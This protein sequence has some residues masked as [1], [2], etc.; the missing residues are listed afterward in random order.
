MNTN[1]IENF[2]PHSHVLGAGVRSGQTQIDA[3]PTTSDAV[4]HSPSFR[5]VSR[6]A[7][8]PRHSSRGN[9]LWRG[10]LL[11]LGLALCFSASS[12]EPAKPNIIVIIG[13]DLGYADIGAN[14][15]KE[16]PTPNIDSIAKKGVRF[17]CGYVSG[18]YC[19]PTRAG[20]LS[21]RYQQRFGHEFNPGGNGES[22]LHIGLSLKE[23][24]L[25]EK[26]KEAG[27]KTALVGKWHLG[28]ADQFHPQRRGFDEYFGFTGGAHSYTN[29]PTGTRNSVQRGTNHVEEK[30]F[31]TAAF[32]REALAF[33]ERNKTQP[34][35]LQ[36]AYNAVHGP[37]DTDP[38]YIERFSH[39]TDERRRRFAGLLAGLDDGIGAVLKKLR[40][41]GL[42]E[43]TLVFFFSDNGG[44]T[45]AN[46]SKNEP[47]RG[48]KAQTWEGGIRVPFLA[49]W[50][51]KLPAGKVYDQPIIQLDVHATSLAVAGVTE[52]NV[53][54]DGVNLLPFLTGE[55]KAAP[56]DALYWRFG[57]QSA[58]RK[59]DWKLVRGAGSESLQL[60]NLATDIGEATDLAAKEPAKFKELEADWNKWNAELVPPA[61]GPARQVAGGARRGQRAQRAAEAAAKQSGTST[62]S[63]KDL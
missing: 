4:P 24:T 17:S 15:G 13:D 62:N 47:L 43:N 56:H 50:K 53:K 33:V 42:E 30:E 58:I 51:G 18:P 28:H 31:L 59:G 55:N 38:K 34:F 9:S 10:F 20:L 63:V 48:F 14:G 54:L 57:Q 27:Y 3:R 49:Q 41:A 25:P 6:V 7:A 44:P 21:G 46:T 2:P 39:I 23:R 52:K 19:S 8:R 26:L 22:N 60:F 37:L 1:T 16:I 36:L 32:T 45:L 29:T 61:W 35:F 5:I 40:D 11:A 12:A